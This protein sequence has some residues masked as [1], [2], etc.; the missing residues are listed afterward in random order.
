MICHSKSA[1][2]GDRT[3]RCHQDNKVEQHR[4]CCYLEC[5]RLTPLIC[6]GLGAAKLHTQHAAVA[7]S[8]MIVH[9]HTVD[10]AYR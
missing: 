7:V 2:D 5:I 3:P 1:I 10:A 4:E 6:K 8:A 9:K